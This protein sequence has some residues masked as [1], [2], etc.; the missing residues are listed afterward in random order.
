MLYGLNFKKKWKQSILQGNKLEIY[1][2][3]TKQ[4]FSITQVN[5]SH[6]KT[7]VTAQAVGSLVCSKALGLAKKLL[8]QS[9]SN[10][11]FLFV[12][13]SLYLPSIAMSQ[14]FWI[15]SAPEINYIALCICINALLLI[16]N[17]LSKTPC[18]HILL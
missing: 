10:P 18:S 14:G 9:F 8:I 15:F 5:S 11:L 6:G 16:C 12:F 3:E 4:L 13:C 2:R 17:A 1:P 7:S